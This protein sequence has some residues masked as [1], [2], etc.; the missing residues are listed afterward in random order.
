M[1]RSGYKPAPKT[2][3]I[4]KFTSS[5]DIEMFKIRHVFTKDSFVNITTTNRN[6]KNKTTKYNRVRNLRQFKKVLRL[7]IKLAPLKPR[8]SVHS[9]THKVNGRVIKKK[10]GFP[11]LSW[12]AVDFTGQFLNTE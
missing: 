10:Y 12:F 6:G 2:Y 9:F 7:L 1:N 5:M 4:V 8:I 3:K 11:K